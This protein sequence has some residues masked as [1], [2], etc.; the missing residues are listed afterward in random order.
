MKKHRKG[1]KR[2]G[3]GRKPL[4][5]SKMRRIQVTLADNHIEKASRI[6]NGNVS[7]GIRTAVDKL[8]E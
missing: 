1:G 8:P 4:G 7:A 2:E 3:A 5:P 6:G